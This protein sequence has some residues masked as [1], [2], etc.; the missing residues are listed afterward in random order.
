MIR[1]LYLFLV[2]Q[3]VLLAG[4]VSASTKESANCIASTCFPE[5]FEV[6]GNRFV[7][8]NTALYRFWGF[9]VYSAALFVQKDSLVTDPNTLFD[10]PLALTLSYYRDIQA[11]DFIRSSNELLEKNPEYDRNSTEGIF[12]QFYASFRDISEGQSYTLVWNPK[13]GLEL[14]LDGAKLGSLSDTAAGRLYLEIW[15]SDYSIDPENYRKLT[16]VEG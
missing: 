5:R 16:R 14:Y 4:A 8:N 2:V 10:H 12:E 9:K 3:V 15:L 7:L 11:K 1:I 13:E 6:S